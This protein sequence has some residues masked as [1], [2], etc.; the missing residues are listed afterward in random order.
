MAEQNID[1]QI[2]Q[3]QLEEARQ[4]LVV[5]K[6]QVQEFNEKE[7][8]AE[9]VTKIR[10]ESIKRQK[11]EEG[12]RQNAC[13]HK[14]GGKN[15][16]GFINGDGAK[17]YCVASHVLPTKEVYYMCTRCQREWHHPDWIRAIDILNTGKSAMTQSQYDKMLSEYQQ[18]AQFDHPYTETTESALFNIPLLERVRTSLKSIPFAKEPETVNV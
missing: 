9:R 7:A 2:K 1:E 16:Q 17:G 4:R 3:L 6:R 10:V 11:E 8:D 14:T 5:T 12:R 18:A 15:K 13:R